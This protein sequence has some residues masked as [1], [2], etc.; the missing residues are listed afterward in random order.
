MV[1]AENI[2]QQTGKVATA[3]PARKKVKSTGLS[4]AA[5]IALRILVIVAFLAVWQLVSGPLIPD[6]AISKP[7]E[8]ATSLWKVLGSAAGWIDIWATTFEVVVG[9]GLGIALGAVLGLL[10]GTFTTAGRVLE[11]LM[12]AINGIP[13]IALAPLFMLFFG[14]GAWSKITIA[15]MGVAF[16]MFY[17]IYLGLRQIDRELVQGIQMMGGRG[18]HTLFYV[19]IPTLASPFFAALKAGGPLA[20]LGVIGGEF[21]A[22]SKGVG[23]ELFNSAMA[24]DAAGEFAGL[25]ILVVMT[26]ILNGFLGQ[27]DA[28]ALRRLGLG[29]RRP[30]QRS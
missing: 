13:K 8:V 9:F 24:L 11:P 14:I 12:A 7:T 5:I 10:L 3:A 6:Y 22:S 21:I 26:L 16:V 4:N 1:T 2:E 18:R 17:N 28:Y 23:H 20:I 27:L 15:A 29:V 19:T 30:A 25:I